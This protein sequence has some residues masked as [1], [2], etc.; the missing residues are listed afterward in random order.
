MKKPQKGLQAKCPAVN[1]C[2]GGQAVEVHPS[3]LAKK[4]EGEFSDQTSVWTRK[5]VL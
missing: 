4:D 3:F 1:N 5:V 2:V